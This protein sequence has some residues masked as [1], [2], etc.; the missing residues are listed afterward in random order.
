MQEMWDK[1]KTIYLILMVFGLIF[2]ILTIID[3]IPFFNLNTI[4]CIS[5]VIP[6]LINPEFDIVLFFESCGR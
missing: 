1:M 2:G 3:A 4:F 6:E 5:L